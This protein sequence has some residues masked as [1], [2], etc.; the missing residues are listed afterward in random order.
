VQQNQ[1]LPIL[2]LNSSTNRRHLPG[3][4]SIGI[5]WMAISRASKMGDLQSMK[6][7]D[8]GG[9]FPESRYPARPI[10]FYDH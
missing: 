10:N 8:V 2:W 7:A 4:G 6:I 5:L 3:R 1:I 9:D